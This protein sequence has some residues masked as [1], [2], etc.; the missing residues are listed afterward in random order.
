MTHYEIVRHAIENRQQVRATYGGHV[1]DMAPHMLGTKTGVPHGLFYQFAGTSEVGLAPPGSPRNW[2]CP[3][4]E[5]LSDVSVPG[6]RVAFGTA[7][8][9]ASA[10]CRHGRCLGSGSGFHPA[11]P[12]LQV[13]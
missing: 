10:L 1:R 2:R 8:P 6:R 5:G 12:P 3:L 7:R 4:I 13:N 11:C 9:P